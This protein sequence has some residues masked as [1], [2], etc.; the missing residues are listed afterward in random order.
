MSLSPDDRF[1]P[2]GDTVAQARP[3]A[4]I[5]VRPGGFDWADAGIG[6]AAMIGAG[7]LA[8]GLILVGRRRS[9]AH[10]A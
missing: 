1:G 5:V 2:R 3:P 8:T 10:P 9:L 6:A 4:T 7:L